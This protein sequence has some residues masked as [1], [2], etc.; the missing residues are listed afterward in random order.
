M[1]KTASTIHNRTHTALETNK[2]INTGE[3]AKVSIDRKQ[4]SKELLSQI[5]LCR[6]VYKLLQRI[7]QNLDSGYGADELQ[8]SMKGLIFEKLHEVQNLTCMNDDQKAK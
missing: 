7:L 3:N 6:F 4:I 8:S 5:H 1:P 2:T